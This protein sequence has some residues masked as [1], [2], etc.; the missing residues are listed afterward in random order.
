MGVRD[1]AG[2]AVEVGGA[3]VGL[4][5]GVGDDTQLPETPKE[6]VTLK[7]TG[8]LGDGE[9]DKALVWEAMP[10]PV[11]TTLPVPEGD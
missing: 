2:L 10:L 4:F 1:A 3:T 5:C 9:G 7:L 6:A 11:T 8:A